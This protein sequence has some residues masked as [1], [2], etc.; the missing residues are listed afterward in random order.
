MANK[1][2]K[3]IK[4][5]FLRQPKPFY[6]EKKSACGARNGQQENKIVNKMIFTPKNAFY[7]EEKAPAACAM[8]NK[9]IKL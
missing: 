2:I 3:I 1:L 7:V 4:K 8:A 9:K 6:E 5:R